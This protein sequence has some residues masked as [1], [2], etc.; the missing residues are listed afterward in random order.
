MAKT[1]ETEAPKVD[2]PAKPEA[3]KAEA[4]V[5]EVKA[6]T[7]TKDVSKVSAT[8]DVVP[9]E[10]FKC[11]HGTKWYSFVKGVKQSVPR[12]MFEDSLKGSGKLQHTY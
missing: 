9:A 2:A 12:S 3:P 5:A 11:K 7:P 8:V 4:P 6:P 10:T 1:A